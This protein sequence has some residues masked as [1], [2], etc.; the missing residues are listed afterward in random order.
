M[1]AVR[2]LHALAHSLP[3]VSGY[4]IRSHSVLRTQRSLGIDAIAVARSSRVTHVTEEF[5][6]G[7]PYIWLPS[8]LQTGPST[9]LSSV[10]RMVRL[11][12]QLRREVSGRGIALLHAHS[13]SLNGIAA[14]WV[15]NRHR[16]P[17]I[18]EMRSLWEATA[19]E[20][21]LGSEGT[22]R[23]RAARALET[24]L[25]RRVTALI[26]ISQGLRDE[27][28]RR[29]VP[30]ERVFRAPNGVDTGLFRPIPPDADLSRQHGLAGHI[31]FGYLGF[32]FA[33]EGVDVLL[34]AFA[35]IA[36]ALPRSRLLLVGDGDEET[37]L[38][39]LAADL[40]IESKVVFAGAVP[41]D[42]VRRW[43]SVCDV[44]VYPRRAGKVT[45]LVTPLKPLEAMAMGK[46]IV[47]AA[48]GGL[49]ELIRDGET[50]LLCRSDEPAALA[51]A[52]ADIGAAPQ[53]RQAIGASAR[54][55]V[56]EE[57]DWTHL[58]PLYERV[59]RGLIPP[60]EDSAG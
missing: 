34:R 39:A 22:M 51:A 4:S 16:L 1:T 49:Q 38:R 37:A 18:Y 41:H 12:R 59:Y 50:G 60:L 42:D 46:P 17:I 30:A 21:H 56:C 36:A 24:W 53:R 45:A 35:Q 43:Y 9:P 40:G 3:E 23:Y 31:V 33:Y 10:S 11:A 27:A 2:V 6:D 14:L 48:V 25:I 54:R 29:G 7:V 15:A 8:G 13:P 52:L 55:F 26:V 57:R 5:I 19:V 58:G 44:L 32:F 20:R 47:A 28:V